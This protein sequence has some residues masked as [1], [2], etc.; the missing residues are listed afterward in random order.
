[1]DRHETQKPRGVIPVWIGMRQKPRGVIPVWIGMRQKPRGVIPVW[2]S[3]RQKPRGVIPVWISMRQKP[4][5]VIPVWISNDLLQQLHFQRLYPRVSLDE[6]LQ[7]PANTRQRHTQLKQNELTLKIR[8]LNSLTNR[9][10][11]NATKL[12]LLC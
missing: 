10:I 6:W 4:R 7:H 2:I 12:H 3:M 5:G 8:H 1:M 9:K 11:L